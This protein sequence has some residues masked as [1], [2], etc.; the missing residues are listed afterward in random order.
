MDLFI[1]F[2]LPVVVGAV[3]LV[4]ALRW[5]T[6]ARILIGVF[7]LGAALYNA[8]V[9]LADP[10]RVLTGLVATAPI[11]LYRD[12]VQFAVAWTVA[13]SLMLAVIAFETAVGCLMLWRG[14]LVRMALLA[15]GAWGIGMLPVLPPDGIALGVAISGVPGLA[16]LLLLRRGYPESVFAST[17]RWLHFTSPY[18][19]DR[20]LRHAR[21][22]SDHRAPM[23]TMKEG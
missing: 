7:F 15:A 9:T 18:P 19:K 5:P 21:I 17:A 13:G 2:V 10:D 20:S 14:P 16:A 22:P 12:V 8:L 6:V 23:T 1:G 4:P 11:P 3:F